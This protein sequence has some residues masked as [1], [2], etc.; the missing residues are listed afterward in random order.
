MWFRV[1]PKGRDISQALTWHASNKPIDPRRGILHRTLHNQAGHI[2]P[3]PGDMARSAVGL[4]NGDLGDSV[5]DRDAG[6]GRNWERLHLIGV[7]AGR[8][9]ERRYSKYNTVIGSHAMNTAMIPFE[10]VVNWI[11]NQNRSFYYIVNVDLQKKIAFTD[12]NGNVRNE[13]VPCVLRQTVTY[14]SEFN[15][16]I[17]ITIEQTHTDNKIQAMPDHTQV[18]YSA[19]IKNEDKMSQSNYKE[20]LSQINITNQQILSCQT[21]KKWTIVHRA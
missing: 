20:T 10:G 7:S 5:G 9:N 3:L 8:L 4:I 21:L 16:N 12:I 17:W 6:L 18:D 14:T 13:P 1:S 11:L 15:P 2:G 19:E